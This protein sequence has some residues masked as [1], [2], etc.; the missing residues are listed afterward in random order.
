MVRFMLTVGFCARLKIP[1]E[2]KKMNIIDI[3]KNAPEGAERYR[4]FD[5]EGRTEYYATIDG[6]KSF[7][8][9]IVDSWVACFVS[10][11]DL[12]TPLPKLKTEWVKV[13]DPI[14]ELAPELKAGELYFDFNGDESNKRPINT[15]SMLVFLCSIRHPIYRKVE[16]VIDEKQEFIRFVNERAI[17]YANER[18]LILDEDANIAFFESLYDAGCRFIELD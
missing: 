16:K 9:A 7:Y 8:N 15:E 3:V 4:V 2:I 1:K 14:F 6:V 18:D 12:S 10:H 11:Y 13:E 5:K 17:K